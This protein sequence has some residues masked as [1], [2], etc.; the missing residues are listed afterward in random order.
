[1]CKKCKLN[2]TVNDYT[3]PSPNKAIQQNKFELNNYFNSEMIQENISKNLAIKKLP[4]TIK[5]CL[6]IPIRF[7]VIIS[8]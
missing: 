2:I 3:Y 7:L 6:T 5:M 8:L 1:M 4:L